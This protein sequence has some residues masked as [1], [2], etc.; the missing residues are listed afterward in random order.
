MTGHLKQRW[1][2]HL[3]QLVRR[4]GSR[5]PQLS[6]SLPHLCHGH[7]PVSTTDNS[8][9]C[10]GDSFASSLLV[11]V[12]TVVVLPL[13]MGASWEPKGRRG[14]LRVPEQHCW[15]CTQKSLKTGTPGANPPALLPSAVSPI[16]CAG[17]RCPTLHSLP[18]L[19]LI[20]TWSKEGEGAPR[21]LQAIQQAHTWHSLE[22]WELGPAC[23]Q[24]PLLLA[25]S[26]CRHP[27][28][29]GSGPSPLYASP[30]CT[31]STRSFSSQ[32]NTCCMQEMWV[33]PDE[34]IPPPPF[35]L[36]EK[37]S[38]EEFGNLQSLSKSFH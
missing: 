10:P 12:K 3:N 20:R 32:M 33:T 8:M 35:F 36:D 2:V 5:K 18:R 29:G 9:L 25:A 27:E 37:P 38:R 14:Q 7:S 16:T 28:P 11:A 23:G 1:Y 19:A 4:G 6:P 13:W 21:F 24:A 17:G 31:L 15:G 34:M 30:A 26:C 22:P